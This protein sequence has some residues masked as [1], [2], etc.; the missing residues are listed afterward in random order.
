MTGYESSIVALGAPGLGKSTFAASIAEIVDPSEVLPLVTKPGEEQSFG[1]RKWGLRENAEIYHDLKWRPGAGVL[2]ADAYKRLLGRLYELQDDD[3]YGAIILDPLTDAFK[4]AGHKILAPMG[5][6]ARSE[7]KGDTFWYFDQ[8]SNSAQE[9]VDALTVLSSDI[10]SRPKWVIATIHTQP[11]KEAPPGKET[12][13][14]ERGK[15]IEYEGRVLA[16]IDGSYRRKILGDF[17][18]AV[19]CDIEVEKDFSTNPPTEDVRYVIQV[20]PDRDRHAKVRLGPSLSEKK[21]PN[22][23]KSLLEAI[24]EAEE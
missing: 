21:I 17:S 12:S 3:Q 2:E 18:L 15:G 19:Y 9:F 22:S 23:M 11:P 24:R 8:L 6:G 16:Q 1:Y 20:K 5:I 14:D 10:V 4:L 7:L 13:A